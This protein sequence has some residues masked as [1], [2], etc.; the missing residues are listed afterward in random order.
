[1]EVMIEISHVGYLV[2]IDGVILPKSISKATG[3]PILI[4]IDFNEIESALLEVRR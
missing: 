3:T 1:M 2:L 4:D